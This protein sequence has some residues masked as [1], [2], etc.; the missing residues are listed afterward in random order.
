MPCA[1]AN[2]MAR[3][4][5]SSRS[6]SGRCAAALP[7]SELPLEGDEARRHRSST[8]LTMSSAAQVSS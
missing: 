4:L 8:T 5:K 3:R 2:S 6:F 7:D 1:S